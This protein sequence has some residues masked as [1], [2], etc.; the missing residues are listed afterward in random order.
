MRLRN[1]LVLHVALA[2]STASAA[3][4][5]CRDARGVPILSPAGEASACDLRAPG[6]RSTTTGGSR[7]SL[8]TP[9]S[10]PRVSTEVQQKRDDDR[11][12]ILR[13]ELEAEK[14]RMTRLER[15]ATLSGTAPSG[16]A[17]TSIV[18]PSAADVEAQLSRT[19]QNVLAIQ[20]EL[21]GSH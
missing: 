5:E 19:R 4:V 18:V 20:R 17:T 6:F 13:E 2:T 21:S 11:Q 16:G 15:A 3:I 7:A 1:S 10:F 12:R 9:P 14:A 8:P